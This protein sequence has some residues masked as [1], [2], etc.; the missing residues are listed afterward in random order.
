MNYRRLILVLI[1]FCLV[2]SASAQ[3]PFTIRG[4]IFKRPGIERAAQILIRNLRSKD[5]MVCDELGGFSIKAAIGDTLLFSKTNFTDQ[6]VV[7]TGPGDLLV[8]MQP[9][10]KLAE[11]TIKGQTKRQEL[12][13][14]MGQYHSEG[15]FYNGKPPILSFLASPI[16]GFY[17]LFG[18]T[19]GRARRF[20]AYSKGELEYTEVQRRYTLALVKRVT[21]TSDS[22]AKKF[23]E[24]YTPSFEDLK[25]WDDYELIRR[26]KKSYD[27]YDKMDDKERLQHINAPTF[28]K[29]K[30]DTVYGD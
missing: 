26:I 30:K 7:V 10:I 28:L 15:T 25:E 20:A 21:N 12:G 22:T 27:Y 23:M 5:L 11:V 19:P 4:T 8:Y 14:I 29:S 13:E 17:E 16:T 3:Q 2:L 1:C 24:Y 9:V 6:K 18:T